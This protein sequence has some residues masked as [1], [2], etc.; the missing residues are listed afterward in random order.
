MSL[1]IDSSITLS[2]YFQDEQTSAADAVLDRI[3][4]EGAI[5][6][7]LWPLEVANGLRSAVLRKRID[8]A[9]RNEAMA[10]LT[11]LAIVIDSETGARA[12]TTTLSLSDQFQLTPYDAAYL[13]LAQRLGLP[14][15]TL[16]SALWAAG[17]T[18]GLT[19]LG[20]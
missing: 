6:P 9:Y 8:L 7:A 16:D 5:V 13:E 1:V 19:L 12:W 15:A 4:D 20:M 10:Q 3:E 17:G 11:A 2:W 14:L 18:L